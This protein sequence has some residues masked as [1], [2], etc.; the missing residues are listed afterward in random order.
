MTALATGP[1][2]AGLA[3]RLDR[4]GAAADRRED[5][6]LGH[7]EAVADERIVLAHGRLFSTVGTRPAAKTLQSQRSRADKLVVRIFGLHPLVLLAPLLAALSL[8]A[9][10][11]EPASAGVPRPCASAQLID[12][13][14]RCDE[15]LITELPT[16][17]PAASEQPLGPGD[18]VDACTVDRMPPDQLAVLAQ[19]IDINTASID[20]LTSLPGIGPVLAERIAAGR[21]YASVDQ[22][23]AV[24]GIGPAKLEAVRARARVSSSQ[25]Q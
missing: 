2:F 12:G 23:D 22:L 17:C 16:V 8:R 14:L 10:S 3:D 1:R 5:L 7:R 24:K 21:P 19:P 13:Q 4:I 20:E 15:E 11:S 6:G 25:S 9:L 18:A